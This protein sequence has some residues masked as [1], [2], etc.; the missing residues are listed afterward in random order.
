MKYRATVRIEHP[1]DGDL[2]VSNP[3]DA[4]DYLP[5]EKAALYLE[6][7]LIERVGGKSAP[8]PDPAAGE[9]VAAGADSSTESFDEL[10]GGT[11]PDVRRELV[12]GDYDEFL[13]E[14]RDAERSGGKRK[15][16]LDAIKE[17]ETA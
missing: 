8:E 13:K 7:G 4:C 9:D 6:L 17:R 11:V 5:E 3:G 16:V 1:E 12:T 2:H 14:L 15:G 10:L